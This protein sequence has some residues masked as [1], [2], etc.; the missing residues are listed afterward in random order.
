LKKDSGNKKRSLNEYR[1][2]KDSYYISPHTPV[3]RSI[4]LLCDIYPNDSDLGKEIRKHFS[5]YVKRK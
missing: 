3:E 5:P 1:Q 2:T 4:A